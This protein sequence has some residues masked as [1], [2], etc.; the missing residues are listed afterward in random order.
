MAPF[1]VAELSCN[2]LGDFS[3]AVALVEAAAQSGASA[4][5]LQTFEPH[6]MCEPD[7]VIE[8]GPWAGRKLLDLYTE[9]H[10]PKSWHAPLFARAKELG[11][12]AFSSVFHKDDV[13][14]LETLNCPRYKISSFEILDLPL[15]RHAAET[16][17]PLIISCGMATI[18]EIN[19]AV[20]AAR[21]GPVTLLKCTSAYPAEAADAHLLAGV[22]STHMFAHADPN[23]C[24]VPLWGLS[25]HTLTLGVVTAA[26]ALGASMVE[27][28]FTLSRA[29]GGPDALFS[30]EPSEFKAMVQL[31]REAAAAIGEVRYGPTES[32]M[33]SLPLRR[34]PGGKRGS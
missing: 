18:E 3:R 10:T 20:W 15:I 16:K 9:C 8:S 13:D 31:C 29:H 2:H 19:A 23:I 34:K 17:K 4:I 27:R 6:Q 5:K 28:H 11:I 32:E 12:E 14:F 1:F 7:V 22:A 30:T 33:C 21:P 26:V 24:K 25:D